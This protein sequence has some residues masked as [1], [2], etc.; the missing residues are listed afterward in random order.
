MPGMRNALN[1]YWRTAGDQPLTAFAADP[2]WYQFYWYG[3]HAASGHRSRLGAFIEFVKAAATGPRVRRLLFGALPDQTNPQESEMTST[4]SMPS[5]LA[6]PAF[7]RVVAGRRGRRGSDF[8]GRLRA[9]PCGADRRCGAH[10]AR[11]TEHRGDRFALFDHDLKREKPDR[12][13]H[14]GLPKHSSA[15]EQPWLSRTK[16][17]TRSK[18]TKS[19]TGGRLKGCSRYLASGAAGRAAG[20]N[21]RFY[22]TAVSET[23]A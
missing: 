21:S 15:G 12:L 7:N 14:I 11:R 17:A 4:R 3:P 1:Q 23:S 13:R 5:T 9:L 10:R 22:A 2:G 8:S 18:S 16:S 20:M 19:Q 6:M